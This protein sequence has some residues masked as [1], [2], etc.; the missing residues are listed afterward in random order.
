VTNTYEGVRARFDEQAGSLVLVDSTAADDALVIVGKG[1]A[2]G[3]WSFDGGVAVAHWA[4]LAITECKGLAAAK[5]ADLAALVAK[6]PAVQA[7]P[8]DK[9]AVGGAAVLAV[10]PGTYTAETG[11]DEQARWLRFTRR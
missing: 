11:G 6:K 1:V 8:L 10:A 5:L 2:Q 7:K 9:E 3:T 4:G